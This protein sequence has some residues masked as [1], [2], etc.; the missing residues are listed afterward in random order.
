MYRTGIGDLVRHDTLIAVH[1]AA[2]TIALASGVAVVARRALFELY[3]WSLV[4]M[5]AAL[6]A[7]VVVGWPVR[8]PG[9]NGVFSAL[10]VLAAAMV[11]CA[12]RARGLRRAS[13]RDPRSGRFLDLVGFTLISLFDGFVIVAVLTRGGPVWLAVLGGVLGVVVGRASLHRVTAEAAAA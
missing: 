5:A 10:T 1:A 13:P 4:V 7:A 2:G 9:A 6:V 8:P 11:G 12:L 3:F